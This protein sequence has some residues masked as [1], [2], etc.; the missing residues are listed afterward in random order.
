[1]ESGK[2]ALGAQKAAIGPY[3]LMSG[4]YYELP[5]RQKGQEWKDSRAIIG[6]MIAVQWFEEVRVV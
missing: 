3:V 6:K 1:V 2:T 4:G 5:S